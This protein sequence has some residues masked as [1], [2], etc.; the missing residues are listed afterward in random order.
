M[1]ALQRKKDAAGGQH[2]R[3]MISTWRRRTAMSSNP[4]LAQAAHDRAP[5]TAASQLRIAVLVP[6]Y[7]EE[8]AIAKVV[9]DFRAA[10]P[11]ATIYVYDNNSKDGTADVAR[12]SGAVV[13]NESHQGKGYVV[14]R[15]FNDIEADVYVLVDG[16][17]TYDAPSAP[18]MVAQLLEDHL[19]MVVATR[20]DVEEK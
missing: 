10:L 17:A 12:A 14:R 18:E 20:V 15:M 11:Q 16:D 5:Q 3:F 8:H 4:S 13:R 7:N 19:D 9:A 1:V 6:C 2:L